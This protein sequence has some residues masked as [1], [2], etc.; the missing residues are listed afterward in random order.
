MYYPRFRAAR[1]RGPAPTR[2]SGRGS[3]KGGSE[4]RRA[5]AAVGVPHRDA[6]LGADGDSSGSASLARKEEELALAVVAVALEDEP[7]PVGRE[8]RVRL[9]DAHP[10]RERGERPLLEV[11][12]EDA[13]KAGPPSARDEDNLAPIGRERGIHV[14]GLARDERLHPALRAPRSL[15]ERHRHDLRDDV[16][17]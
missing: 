10:L 1:S 13:L 4:S 9:G 2:S 15:V 14:V 11:R 3:A 17:S 6:L 8:E 5:W 16:D 7:L 12:A